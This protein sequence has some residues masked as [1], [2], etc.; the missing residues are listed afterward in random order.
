MLTTNPTDVFDYV[1]ESC[2]GGIDLPPDEFYQIHALFSRYP[3]PPRPGN[4]SKPPFRPHS[5]Q[6]GPQKPFKRYDGPIYLPP[7]IFKLLSQDAMRGLKVYNNEAINRFRQSKVY[8]AEVVEIPHDDPPE[9]SVHNNGPS[10][11]LERDLNI[12]DNP[13]S[14]FVNGQCHSY[15][16]LD[17]ALKAYQAYQVPCPQDSTT[18]PKRTITTIRPTM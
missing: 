6:S 2:N 9:P 11:F 8:K 16:D 18:I 15:E 12:P 1:P 14:D 7:Q 10:D 17:Q 13:I 5:Q 3:P 4:P